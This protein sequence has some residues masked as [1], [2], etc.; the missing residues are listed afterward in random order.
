MEIVL[1]FFI[2]VGTSI[3][4]SLFVK[5][6]NDRFPSA[7]DSR[8]F[9]TV[10]NPFRHIQISRARGPVETIR[11]VFNAWETKD[12]E[13]YR[14]CWHDEAIKNV[15]DY[16]ST[17]QHVDEIVERF[18]TNSRSYESI[19]IKYV[20]I[21]SVSWSA[22]RKTAHVRTR[23][24]QRLERNDGLLIEERGQETYALTQGQGG[25]W[26]IRANWDESAVMG[27]HR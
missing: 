18:R 22:D 9:L 15:G 24:G 12:E 4:T 10:K 19:E 8:F 2:G 17:K 23:Y 27:G 6:F 21:E 1:G 14:S 16:F 5:T 13:A 26:L 3:L 20:N 11:R 25:A 7:S